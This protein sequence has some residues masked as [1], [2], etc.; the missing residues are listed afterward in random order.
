MPLS[1]RPFYD[2]VAVPLS[3]R[4]QQIL[5]EIEKN[6][7]EE[8]PRFARA[9]RS[10]PS[11]LSNAGGLRLGALLFLVGLVLLVAFFVSS[12]LIVGV[13]AFGAM[14]AGIVVIASTLRGLALAKTQDRQRFA[15][16]LRDFETKLRQRYKKG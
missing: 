1:R 7:Y 2:F 14:V 4:E 3:E 8:D 9:V 12:S 5:Q 10:R 15:R 6:L 11:I 16:A 13:A